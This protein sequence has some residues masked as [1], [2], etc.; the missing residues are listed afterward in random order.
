MARRQGLCLF[1]YLLVSLREVLAY[2]NDNGKEPVGRRR[3][4]RRGNRQL[5]GPRTC[6]KH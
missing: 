3:M 4:K 1:A 2:V 6:G 5:I